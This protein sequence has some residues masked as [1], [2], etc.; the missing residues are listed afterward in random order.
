MIVEFPCIIQKVT[1]LADGGIRVTLDL[2]EDSV[3]Q[4]AQLMELRRQSAV[5]TCR[6][7]DGHEDKE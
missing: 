1:T 6:V 3:V 7:R 5:L 4:A 2:Q